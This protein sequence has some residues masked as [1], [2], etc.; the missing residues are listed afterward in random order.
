[1]Q[2]L[3]SE[4]RH[5]SGE[6]CDMSRRSHEDEVEESLQLFR[7]CHHG[8]MLVVFYPSTPINIKIVLFRVGWMVDR[9][10]TNEMSFV[11]NGDRISI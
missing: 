11:L 7:I 2:E 8:H 6:L 9:L 3:Q 4:Q 10:N 1:M 5:S